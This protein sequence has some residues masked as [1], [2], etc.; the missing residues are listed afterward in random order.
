MSDLL[1]SCLVEDEDVA[2]AKERAG[3]TEELFL[4]VRQVDLV[5][6]GVQVPLFLDCRK[7]L[8]AL[9]R[10]QDISVGMGPCGIGIQSD[11]ALEEKRVLRDP[12]DP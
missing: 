9:E 2:W 6:L 10:C 7:E 3:Q 12:V 5:H 4:A 8:D 1:A 11:A